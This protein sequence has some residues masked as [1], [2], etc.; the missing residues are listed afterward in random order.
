MKPCCPAEPSGMAAPEHR[1]PLWRL[2]SALSLPLFACGSPATS[3]AG[4][5]TEPAPSFTREQREALQA[6]HDEDRPP[7]NDPSN[8]VADDPGARRFGQRLFV[9]PRLSGRLLEGDNDGTSATLGRQGEA[10]RVS[11]AGCHLPS[12]G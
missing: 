9:D 2:A 3:D 1:G 4:P 10:G 6:L 7:P 11:C 12:G 5:S 8:R